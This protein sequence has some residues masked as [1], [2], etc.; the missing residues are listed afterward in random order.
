MSKLYVRTTYAGQFAMNVTRFHSD[1]FGTM[2]GAQTKKMMVYFPIRT[3]QARIEFDVQFASN[4]DYLGFQDFVR[5]TQRNGLS[6]DAEPGVTLYWPER[7][8]L[9]WSGIIKE[10]V[11]GASR[12][13]YAPRA[14]FAVELVDSLTSVRTVVSSIAPIFDTVY[15]LGS[16]EGLLKPP[17]GTNN[18][19][20]TGAQGN[21][22]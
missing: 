14:K 1:I 22:K 19:G 3:N 4:G 15:G 18:P 5:T 13:V 11:G 7:S 10:F 2:M 9:N 20:G 8:I 16:P 12:F 17:S 6:N 21:S